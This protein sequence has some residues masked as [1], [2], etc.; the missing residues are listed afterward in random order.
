MATALSK[1]LD[2]LTGRS[3]TVA[4]TNKYLLGKGYPAVETAQAVARLLELGY[5]DDKKT[6]VQWVEYTMR[7]KPLGKE[8]LRRELVFRGI[9]REI[10]EE[11]LE[12][13]DDASEYDLAMQLLEPR[14][15]HQWPRAK[16]YRFLQYRGF[17][18]NT[19]E[20]IK[21]YYE[22]SKGD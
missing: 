15:V 12:I 4:E 14:P 13:L 8:R 1:A 18:Y 17:S 20:K 6:A 3:R 10:V 5:L 19:I 16:L 21:N 22:S 9:K 2:Y 11:V 7:C